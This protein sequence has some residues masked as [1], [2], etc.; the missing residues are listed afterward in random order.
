MTR[1]MLALVAAIAATLSGGGA[2]VSAGTAEIADW[3]VDG[4]IDRT[5]TMIP[6]LV[7][8]RACNSG[9]TAEGRIQALVELSEAGVTV[10]ITVVPRPGAHDCPSNPATPFLLELPEPLGDRALLDG[11]AEP[12][13]V[14]VPESPFTTPVVSPA[15]ATARVIA[16]DHRFAGVGPLQPDLIGQSSWYEAFE[17]GDGFLVTITIGWGDCPAGCIER[18]TWQFEVSRDGVVGAPVE[19]GDPIPVDMIFPTGDGDA[20][21]DIAL[22][23]GPVCPVETTP[24]DPDCAPR[25]MV[26]ATIVVRDATGAEVARLT[27]GDDGHAHGVLPTGTYVFEPQPFEG[28]MG[29]PEALAASILGP[30]GISLSFAY[31]TGIR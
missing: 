12:P 21:V 14:I 9:E 19:G 23:A 18:H 24:P 22:V 1:R 15:D 16:S 27:T 5:S 4:A 10:T 11:G 26:G 29:T 31:D 17:T 6:L 20:P 3:T 8:E 28:L 13:L 7:T 30:A 2:P 25:L